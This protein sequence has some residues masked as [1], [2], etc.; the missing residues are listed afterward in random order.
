MPG[1]GSLLYVNLESALTEL[2]LYYKNDESDSL[3]FSLVVNS[4][5]ARFNHFDHYGYAHADPLFKQQV[6]YNDKTLGKEILYLQTMGGIKTVVKIPD[7]KG[8]VADGQKIAITEAKLII[9]NADANSIYSAPDNLVLFEEDTTGQVYFLS[10]QSIGTEY[11][12]GIYNSNQ[13]NYYFRI[14]RYIQDIFD[15]T[16]DST[17]HLTLIA[18]SPS[19]RGNRLVFGGTNPTNPS[20]YEKRLRLQ[21]VY[22]FL[23]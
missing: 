21:I 8:L 15:G 17:R 11:F 19:V 14:P 2:I 9:S 22:T 16:R 3:S 7:L 18:S 4:A 12:G 5:T 13:Q 6:L 1:K 23:P 10:E 20:L